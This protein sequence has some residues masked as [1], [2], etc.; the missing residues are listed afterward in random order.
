MA[1]WP[2]PASGWE[3]EEGTWFALI[4]AAVFILPCQGLSRAQSFLSPLCPLQDLLFD[5]S[6]AY[7]KERQNG[8]RGSPSKGDSG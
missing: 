2:F 6:V 8:P 5:I 4:S 7:A 3:L 1:G